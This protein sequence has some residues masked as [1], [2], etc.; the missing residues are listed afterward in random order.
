M[1]SAKVKKGSSS[2]EKTLGKTIW[3]PK[4]SERTAAHL[5]TGKTMGKE[6][7]AMNMSQEDLTN[8]PCSV[9]LVIILA[10]ISLFTAILLLP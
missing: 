1:M 5:E 7:F 8:V 6:R 4:S 10:L 9:A 2:E 3:V